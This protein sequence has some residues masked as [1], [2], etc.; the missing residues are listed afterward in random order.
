[1]AIFQLY[2]IFTFAHSPKD[3]KKKSTK[4]SAIA[5]S[6][7]QLCGGSQGARDGGPVEEKKSGQSRA[8]ARGGQ[9]E[10]LEHLEDHKTIFI[11]ILRIVAEQIQFSNYFTPPPSKY[12]V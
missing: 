5:P 10:T 7:P 4:H 3:F 2:V 1:M 9:N 12:E 8:R 11:T 6:A